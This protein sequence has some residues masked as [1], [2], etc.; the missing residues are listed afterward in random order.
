MRQV[1]LTDFGRL[2]R[3][4]RLARGMS[5]LDLALNADVSARHIS[6]IETGRSAPSREMV[7]LLSDTLAMPLRQRNALLQAAGYAPIYRETSFDEPEM[8][9][10]L[11]ALRLILEQHGPLGGAVAFDRRHDLVMANSSFLRI[12]RL[13]LGEQRTALQPLRV[14]PPPRPNLVRLLFDPEGFRPHIANWAEVAREL[15]AR[16]RHEAAASQDP[17]IHELLQ[18]VLAYPGVP[19]D[20]RQPDLDAG[21]AMVLPVE[22]RLPQGTVRLFSTLT[23]LGTARDITLQE[24]CI[25]S[26]H[27]A[28]DASRRLVESLLA[29]A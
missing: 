9:G 29:A 19:A 28:D 20:W 22:I 17:A 26:F 1:E 11:Q 18:D 5:Q 3:R 13:L 7:A 12:S 27:A 10:M 24:L 23:T 6:F 21:G 25:E 16:V 2:L 15:L 4:W 14:P 8:A